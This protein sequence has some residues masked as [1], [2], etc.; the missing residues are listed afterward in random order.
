MRTVKELREY[1]TQ[2][3]HRKLQELIEIVSLVEITAYSEYPLYL[4]EVENLRK[5][6]KKIIGWNADNQKNAEE[7]AREY[8]G[9]IEELS[10]E[11]R[12]TLETVRLEERESFL[13]KLLPIAKFGAAAGAGFTV[14]VIG[15][16]I[17]E[18]IAKKNKK[19]AE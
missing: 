12:Q 15:K 8:K 7:I 3:E 6:L 4:K 2:T 10:K 16:K 13:K 19:G 5:L 1:F 17:L 9:K 14:A 11:K 18:K